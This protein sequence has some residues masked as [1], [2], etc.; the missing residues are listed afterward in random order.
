[1]MIAI[2]IALMLAIALR[3]WLRRPGQ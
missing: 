2:G 1:M 3:G